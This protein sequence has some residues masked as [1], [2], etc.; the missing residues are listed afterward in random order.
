MDSAI[1]VSIWVIGGALTILM[2]FVVFGYYVYWRQREK[3]LLEDAGDAAKLASRK[4]ILQTDIEA[5]RQWLTDQKVELERLQAEREDQERLRAELANLEQQCAAKD[6]ANQALRNEVGELENQR[7]ILSQTLDK[8]KKEIGDLESKRNEAE[9]IKKQLS[10]LRAKHQEA[11]NTVRSLT[12]L[13][14]KVDILAQEKAFLKQRIEAFTEKAKSVR[15]IAN[16]AEEEGRKLADAQ[17]ARQKLQIEMDELNARKSALEQDVN[18]LKGILGGPGKNGNKLAAYDDL[19]KKVPTCLKESE[20]IDEIDE[21]DESSLLQKLKNNLSQEGLIFSSRVIDA[22]HTSLKCH[23]INPITVLAG[24]SGTGKTL[25]PIRYAEIMG[26]HRL[27]MAVQPRWDSPQDMFGFYNYLEKEYK[28]TDLSRALIRMDPFN[29]HGEDF[30][31]LNSDWAKQRMLLVL[32]DEMN[33][34]RTEYYFSEFLSKLELRREV[35]DP[36]IDHKRSQAEIELEAGPGKQR[37]RIWVPENIFFVGTM[38]EDETTQT[39]SDKVLDRA[40]VI[41]FGKPDEKAKAARDNTQALT[42][43]K[44][45]PYKQWE[46]WHRNLEERAEWFKQVVKWTQELNMALDRIGRPFGF[47]VQQAIGQ[48]VANYP[49]VDDEN[50]FKLAFA[51]QVEQ[52]IIPKL[53]GIDLNE[54]NSNECLGDLEAIMD[55]LGDGELNEAF[56]TARKESENLGMFQWRGV[57]RN[58]G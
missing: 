8:L 47:R 36:K 46:S 2:L 57:T 19:L 50:R 55:E 12:A 27:V 28:A 9:V 20:Y 52:K 15:E 18:R 38:N 58:I 13:K 44:Y 3:A 24:V 53:R 17:Q 11:I 23:A 49:R 39:L 7:H 56:A 33:L 22:F 42:N 43:G 6:Q 54:P 25:L 21:K 35:K 40:N 26:M 34:A 37:F 4:Q 48:Y 1:P 5:M 45:L 30:A 16:K 41:R 51:D 31:E 10:E 14:A 29:Y 32:L